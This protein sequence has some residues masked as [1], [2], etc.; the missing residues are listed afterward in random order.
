MR[1]VWAIMGSLCLSLCLSGAAMAEPAVERPEGE[2]LLRAEDERAI[3]E[4]WADLP[5]GPMELLGRFEAVVEVRADA[6]VRIEDWSID[7]AFGDELLVTVSEAQELENRGELGGWFGRYAVVVE[8]LMDGDLDFGPLRLSYLVDPDPEAD[9]V[10]LEP[11]RTRIESGVLTISVRGP[12]GD[13]PRDAAGSKPAIEA[14]EPFDWRLV[15]IAGAAGGVVLPVLGALVLAVR[16]S[17]RRSRSDAPERCLEK[18]AALERVARA[19]EPG[20]LGVNGSALATEA[21]G[22]VRSMLDDAYGLGTRS[23]SGLEMVA[24]AG[25]RAVLSADACDH[26]R[27]LVET[28]EGARFAGEVITE[29]EAAAIIASARELARSVASQRR[30]MA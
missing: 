28:T 11:V 3:V 17:R 19:A 5:E 18:L 23:M 1:T 26:L 7:T 9:P 27:G 8:P 25:V 14:E 15:L 6:G 24:S 29:D 16:S 4:A 2:P 30:A 20:G 21:M 12:G 10:Q 13:V 22:S